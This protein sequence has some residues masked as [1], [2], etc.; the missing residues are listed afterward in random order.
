MNILV[1]EDE[2]ELASALV[3]GLEEEQFCVQLCGEGKAALQRSE[4]G[5]F[6]LILLDVMLPDL[7]GFDMVEELR[8]RGRETLVL[9]LTARD[10]LADVVRGLDAGADGEST[11]RCVA[12]VSPDVRDVSGL[13]RVRRM[14]TSIASG[15]VIVISAI[16]MPH[17]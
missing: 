12:A 1:V 7:S 16:G 13:L 14:I 4:T 3:L 11:L 5:N 17:S 8:L 15:T 6:D 10:S 9:M 2:P